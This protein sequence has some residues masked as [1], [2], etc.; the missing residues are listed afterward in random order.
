[1]GGDAASPIIYAIGTNTFDEPI[2]LTI[3][4]NTGNPQPNSFQP[5]YMGLQPVA[6]GIVDTYY[7]QVSIPILTI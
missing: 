1:M 5:L 6:L 7:F 2:I 4:G 3:G